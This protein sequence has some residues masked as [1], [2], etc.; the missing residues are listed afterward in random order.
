MGWLFD[1]LTEVIDRLSR[2]TFLDWIGVVIVLLL[3]GIAKLLAQ[4][5]DHLRDIESHLGR[6][7]PSDSIVD[8]LEDFAPKKSQ[9]GPVT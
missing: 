8:R 4:C 3:C 7:Q 2:L 9:Q 1:I 6:M 5:K